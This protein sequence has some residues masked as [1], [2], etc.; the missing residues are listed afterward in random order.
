MSPLSEY[1]A[2]L[3]A[4]QATEQNLRSRIKN[5][6]NLRLALAL[7]FLAV[8]WLAIGPRIVSWLVALIPAAAFIVLVLYHERLTRAAA[9]AKRASAFY[10]RGL[11]RL[12]NRWH[13]KGNPGTEYLP[14]GHLYAVDLDIFGT[15]SLF[16]LLCS[17]RTRAG[18]EVL[19]RWLSIPASKVE[20]LKRQE[21]VEELRNKIDLRED[22]ALIGSE[23]RSETH[24]EFMVS[25]ATSASQL[26]GAG[27]VVAASLVG[28]MLVSA[29]FRH[30]Q[31]KPATAAFGAVCG[32]LGWTLLQ[33]PCSG[34]SPDDQRSG[35]GVADSWLRTRTNGTR[36]LLLET[37]SRTAIQSSAGWEKNHRRK[38]RDW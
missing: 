30:R 11:E 7:L 21:A 22:L 16:E 34:I 4:R 10:E 9:R 5:V 37:S 12:E 28:A 35:T 36:E 26:F 17:P 3:A 32:S 15:G 18:E 8:M 2:R 29:I 25:W 24:S 33:K 13:G 20:I 1:Q 27:R 6:S 19:A 31:P 14:E 23:V 38:S